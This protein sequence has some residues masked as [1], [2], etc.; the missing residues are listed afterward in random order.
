MN[1]FKPKKAEKE[2]ISIRL[3]KELLEKIDRLSADIDISRNEMIV[4]CIQYALDNID[5][6]KR[7]NQHGYAFYLLI[8]I[9]R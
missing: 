6:E 2:V 9:I 8:I 4:Q 5:N 7:R 3:N 1:D